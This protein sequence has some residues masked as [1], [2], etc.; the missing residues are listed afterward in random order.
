[1]KKTAI[2]IATTLLGLYITSCNNNVKEQKKE[3]AKN[4][5]TE[6]PHKMMMSQ[7]DERV[8]LNLNPMQ[9]QHQLK[10]MRSHLS[11][12]QQITLLLA[13]D[14]YDKAS[15]IAHSKLGLTPEMKQMCSMF[16]DKEFENIGLGFHNSA[17]KLAKIFKNRNKQE[18]LTA[19]SNTMNYCVKCHATYR[20]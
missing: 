17:D 4:E 12:V 5:T 13:T 20:Q 11:A 15:E 10:N 9:K 14:E 6:H 19:L 1:M 18:S 3:E 7:E 8:S 16:G 2:I